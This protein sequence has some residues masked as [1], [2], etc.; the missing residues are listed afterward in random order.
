MNF[1]LATKAIP[2][3][4]PM[5]R[6]S[7][8]KTQKSSESTDEE[9]LAWAKS[10]RR[11]LQFDPPPMLPGERP[12]TVEQLAEIRYLT[13]LSDLG[14]FQSLGSGQACALIHFVREQQDN[15][16]QELVCE[17]LGRKFR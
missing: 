3:P 4:L 13:K 10:Q 1:L 8:L 6:F 5:I 7:R 16:T 17:A 15:F 14:A 2:S 12:I 11:T 9:L